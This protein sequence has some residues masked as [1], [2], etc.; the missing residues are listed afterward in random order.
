MDR[1]YVLHLHSGQGSDH[2]D[3]MLQAGEALVTWQLPESPLGLCPGSSLPA[4]RLADHRSAYLLYEGPVSHNRGAVRAEDRGRCRVLACRADL[5]RLE[6]ADGLL[7]GLWLISRKSDD[8]WVLY[9]LAEPD[10]IS[11]TV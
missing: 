4:R 6:L 10:M 9:R 2:W 3:F 1:Q 5:W 7:A 8:T 11:P